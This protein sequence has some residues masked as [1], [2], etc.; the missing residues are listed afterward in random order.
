MATSDEVRAQLRKFKRTARLLAYRTTT[1]AAG[2]DFF[3]KRAGGPD[4]ETNGIEI[5]NLKFTWKIE[6]DLSKH[7]NRCDI[8]IYNLASTTR[9][10]MNT[11]PLT[12][13][14]SAGYS[15]VN[16][17]LF[18]G[19]VIHAY[20]KQDHADRVTVLQV[21][22]GT[23][24]YMRSRINRSYRAGT[25]VK[26][27][28]REAAKSM[29]QVL[30]SSIEN[31][32]DL[33]IQIASGLAL[34][35]ATQEAMTRVLSPLGYGY[36]F[37][38]GK[39]QIL[40]DEDSRNDIYVIDESVGMID[41]PKYGDPPKSGKTP[42]M[43]VKMLLYPELLPGGKAEVRSVDVNG[44]FN[45]VKVKHSGDTEGEE[46]FTEV[47]LKPLGAPLTTKRR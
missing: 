6:R 25:T 19:D 23:R 20:S 31:A 13:E 36:S 16:R 44:T 39:L 9:T 41:S 14:L 46:W 28:L 7:P 8:E 24:A 26:T 21:G 22:D 33:N 2:E 42:N 12:I 27:I 4:G 30:P 10:A 11:K 35:G 34:T 47:E 18:V 29:G 38:N 37:Q 32:A 17:T 40:R 5:A 43:Q 45:I 1:P 15:G 3:V